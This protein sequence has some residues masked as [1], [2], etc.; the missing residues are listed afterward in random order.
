MVKTQ[1]LKKILEEIQAKAQ[2]NPKMEVCGLISKK[3][4]DFV[5]SHAKNLSINKKDFFA[6]DPYETFCFENDYGLDVIYH[7]HPNSD[8][9]PTEFDKKMSMN[10]CKPFLIYSLQTGKFSLHVP[11]ISTANKK[12]ISQISKQIST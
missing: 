12:A 7:T 1:S 2:E 10:C 11:K 4:R 6:L 8:E 5:L 3:G 9:T